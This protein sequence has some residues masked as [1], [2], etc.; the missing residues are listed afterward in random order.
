MGQRLIGNLRN[1]Q[2]QE[3]AQGSRCVTKATQSPCSRCVSD[4]SI[5]SERK[6]KQTLGYIYMPIIPEEERNNSRYNTQQFYY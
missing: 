1:F 3:R 5:D 2:P 4:F 6:P